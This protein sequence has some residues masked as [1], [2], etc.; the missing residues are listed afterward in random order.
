MKKEN[1][2][3]E[4]RDR[5]LNNPLGSSPF[6]SAVSAFASPSP[7]GLVLRTASLAKPRFQS[8]GFPRDIFSASLAQL[9]F[10]GL[11]MTGMADGFAV[12]SDE[13]DDLIPQACF[14]W[15]LFAAKQSQAIGEVADF[16]PCDMG[17]C[18][19]LKAVS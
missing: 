6:S 11:F 17:A 10:Q 13:G 19:A 2:R 1:Q 5:F 18:D 3:S 14:G 16:E 7:D 15:A 9:D 8:F 4:V 12:L